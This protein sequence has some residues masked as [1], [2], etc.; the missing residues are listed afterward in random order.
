MN[1]RAVVY[2]TQ[3][4]KTRLIVQNVVLSKTT[5]NVNN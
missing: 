2:V 4:L 1:E 3:F 5:I